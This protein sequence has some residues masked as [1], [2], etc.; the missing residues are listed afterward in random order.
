MCERCAAGSCLHLCVSEGEETRSAGCWK[1]TLRLA[2][3]N[4]L[5]L[6]ISDIILPAFLH[7]SIRAYLVTASD[8]DFLK[9]CFSKCI[10]KCFQGRRFLLA[11]RT[12]GVLSKLKKSE[13]NKTS[14]PRSAR[15]NVVWILPAR[16]SIWTLLATWY[17]TNKC[18]L[19]NSAFTDITRPSH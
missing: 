11:L 15:S 19:G 6:H 4:A 9:K 3:V 7:P 18:C 13:L 8:R 17:Q 14:N 10:S 16:Y 5:T 2:L 12:H 1:A